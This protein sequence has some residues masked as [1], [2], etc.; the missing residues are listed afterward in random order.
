MNMNLNNV[1]RPNTKE[2]CLFNENSRSQNNRDKFIQKYGGTWERQANSW[3]WNQK[4]Q[5][6]IKFSHTKKARNTYHFT[7]KDGTVY[8]TDNFEG[9]CR[10]HELTRSAMGDVL[11]GKRKQHKGYTV[12]RHT[13][14]TKG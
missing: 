4:L 14:E 8:I 2:W 11:T 5:K 13:P 12:I 6:E 10:D 1:N 9:F 3:F 7:Y